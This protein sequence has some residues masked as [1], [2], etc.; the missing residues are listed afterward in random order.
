MPRHGPHRG[1]VQAVTPALFF[2]DVGTTQQTNPKRQTSDELKESTAP[3]PSFSIEA[4][5]EA[6]PLTESL[7]VHHLTSAASSDR[8]QL[9]AATKQLQEWEKSSGFCMHLQSAYM[10]DQL[11]VEVRY[12]AITQL[13]N[14]IDKTWRWSATK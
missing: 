5:G 9:Q 8:N 3:M 12:L 6:N 13:K 10:N 4:P 14:K 2:L 7:L 11:P 1:T